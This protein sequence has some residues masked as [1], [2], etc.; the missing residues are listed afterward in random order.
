MNTTNSDVRSIIT[1]GALKMAEIPL[2]STPSTTIDSS[3]CSERTQEIE[4]RNNDIKRL[5][6]SIKELHDLFM[7]MLTLTEEQ[8]IKIHNIGH[9]TLFILF[10][11]EMIDR[12]EN[13]VMSACDYIQEAVQHTKKAVEY[14]SKARRVS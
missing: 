9:Y 1:H 6:K 5:E 13:N 7:R 8:V 2:D 14:Q 11:G 3:P 4:A 12:I 10:Q